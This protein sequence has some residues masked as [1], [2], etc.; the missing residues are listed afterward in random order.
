MGVIWELGRWV[1]GRVVNGV[2][3][4]VTEHA[5]VSYESY[6][7]VEDTGGGEAARQRKEGDGHWKNRSC[8]SPWG[9]YSVLKFWVFATIFSCLLTYKYSNLV[10]CK[11]VQ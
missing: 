1:V 11:S 4:Q 3:Y 5:S 6:G 10:R 8:G 9:C 2:A 7:E